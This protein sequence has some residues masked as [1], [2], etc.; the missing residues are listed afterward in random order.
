MSDGLKL[1]PYVRVEKR[2]GGARILDDS[3]SHTFDV[4]PLAERLLGLIDGTRSAADIVKEPDDEPTIRRLFLLNLVEGSGDEI[5]DRI[6]RVVVDREKLPF[7]VLEGARFECQGSGGCC[8]NYVFGPLD[9]DDTATIEA[10]PIFETFP[11]LAGKPVFEIVEM[12]GRKLPY[13]RSEDERCIFLDDH[14][15]CRLHAHFGADAKPKMCRLYP[16]EYV[17]AADGIR[18]FDKGSCTTFATSTRTGPTTLE[19]LPRLRKL[20]P[21]V[22]TRLFHDPVI[23]DEYACDYGHFDRFVKHALRLTKAGL[24][25]APETLRAVGRGVRGFAQVLRSFPL[26]PGQPDAAIDAFLAGDP[27]AWY[28]G[29]PPEEQVRAG[30]LLYSELFSALLMA[31][32]MKI[33]HQLP[34]HGYMAL[35]IIRESAQ[36]FHICVG[37]IARVGDPTFELDPYVAG[38]ADVRVAHP[39]IDDV[40]RMSLRQQLFGTGQLVKGKALPAF[41][42][43]ALIHIMSV[44]GARLRASSDGRNQARPEDLSWGQMLATRLLGAGESDLVLLA[45]EDGFMNLL[46][47]LPAV[48]RLDYR[49][50]MP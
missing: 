50:P 20:L 46:E 32:S 25:T 5:V 3:L 17:I 27:A 43:M 31:C 9:E 28:R 7:V 6:H 12:N 16:Y 35:P 44:Y 37:A 18:I 29:E 15:R 41:I 13:L 33:S 34:S 22:P 49:R 19:E 4:G 40:L 1:R 45:A 26:E 42:R 39:E 30:A 47:A 8:M 14:L 36:L 38:V 48:L 23:V 21:Q 2:E 24:G 10:L 11:D